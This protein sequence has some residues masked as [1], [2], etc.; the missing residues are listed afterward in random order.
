MA[1]HLMGPVVV[2]RAGPGEACRRVG[3]AGHRRGPGRNR[4]RGRVGHGG[5]ATLIL[6]TPGQALMDC[7][8]S[9]SLVMEILWGLARSAT[10][11]VRRSTPLR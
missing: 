5:A 10:G 2:D 1:F 3:R 8:S 7:W 11:M 9:V 6:A 4:V